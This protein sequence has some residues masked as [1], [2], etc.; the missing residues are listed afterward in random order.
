MTV[1][2]DLRASDPKDSTLQQ[3]AEAASANMNT[4]LMAGLA[5]GLISTVILIATK[6]F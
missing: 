4:A 1:S 5:I 2:N 6:W 3:R